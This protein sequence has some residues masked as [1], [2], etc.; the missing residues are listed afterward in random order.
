[1]CQKAVFINK[2]HEEAAQLPLDHGVPHLCIWTMALPQGYS[3][4]E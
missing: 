1:M 3:I 4:L 2:E